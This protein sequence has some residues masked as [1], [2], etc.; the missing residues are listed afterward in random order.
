[1]DLPPRVSEAPKSCV[2]VAARALASFSRAARSRASRSRRNVLGRSS[3]PSSAMRG[4]STVATPLA[5]EKRGADA[6]EEANAAPCKCE[7]FEAAN[8]PTVLG[9][10]LLFCAGNLA[11]GAHLSDLR[12]LVR[13][14][15][16]YPKPGIL[17][18]DV[19]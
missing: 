9:L 12:R 3:E 6:P 15:P 8:P 11:G 18:R 16:N 17:F 7:V 4:K 5:S 10:I 14:I 19:T 1:M 13:T 2:R